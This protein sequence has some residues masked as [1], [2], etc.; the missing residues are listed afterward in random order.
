MNPY[1]IRKF[2]QGPMLIPNLAFAKITPV[3]NS[4]SELERLEPWAVKISLT[5]IT[6][7][8]SIR[9]RVSIYFFK[10]VHNAR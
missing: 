4:P 6:Q 1:F 9:N 8:F 7:R 3:R 5:F 2:R 10:K